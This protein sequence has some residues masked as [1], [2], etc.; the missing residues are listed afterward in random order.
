MPVWNF[1][2]V[3]GSA[4]A[5]VGV[6]MGIGMGI[7]HD[8]TLTPVHAHINLLGW[9]SM[10][11]FGLYYRGIAATGAFAWIQAGMGST[12]FVLMTGGLWLF[13]SD[14]SAEIGKHAATAGSFLVAGSFLLFLFGLLRV[15]RASPADQRDPATVAAD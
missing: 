3:V 12:G 4:A 10:M 7:A 13:L 9:V 11:L 2:F 14:T 8:F 15:R 5:V 6:G 1:C